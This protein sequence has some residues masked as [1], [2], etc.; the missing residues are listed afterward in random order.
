MPEH[1]SSG[2]WP[3]AAIRGSMCR[4]TV[5]DLSRR[6]S[7]AVTSRAAARGRVRQARRCSARGA[8]SGRQGRAG[9]P[10]RGHGPTGQGAYHGAQA[11]GGKDTPTGAAAST[12]D[13]ACAAGLGHARGLRLPGGP[14]PRYS[15]PDQRSGPVPAAQALTQ[16]LPPTA[17]RA[18]AV[19][20]T[21]LR[22]VVER[23]SRSPSRPPEEAALQSR[24]LCLEQYTKTHSKGETCAPSRDPV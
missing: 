5:S 9:D 1:I 7:Q 2:S 19:T 16:R 24:P 23:V 8:G 10:A 12:A 3:R 14:G 21:R 15:R 4:A 20:G 17:P 22:G 18:V 13:G 6:A 11:G